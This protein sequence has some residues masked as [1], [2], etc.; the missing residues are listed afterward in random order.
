MGTYPSRGRRAHA[1]ASAS[2]FDSDR[3]HSRKV[4]QVCREVARTLSYA[5]SGC[6]DPL[7]S[8]LVVMDVEPYPDM[9]RLRV[10]LDAGPQ[11]A[12]SDNELLE[13]LEAARGLLRSEVAAALERRRTPDFYFAITP[14]T[15]P[16]DPS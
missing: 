9:A 2:G 15:L 13:H 10:W 8:S 4:A 6:S 12:A 3:Q 14:P 16:E 1:R 5:L 11:P 7:L